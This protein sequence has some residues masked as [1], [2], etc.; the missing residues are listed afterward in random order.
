MCRHSGVGFVSL[1]TFKLRPLSF[2]YSRRYLTIV[3][4][5][6]LFIALHSLLDAL[7]M[8]LRLYWAIFDSW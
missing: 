2:A 8:A 7:L 6:A 1:P 3:V 4:T 5:I